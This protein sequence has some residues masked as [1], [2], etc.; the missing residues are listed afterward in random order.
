MK[1]SLREPLLAAFDQPDPDLPC[2]VRFPTNVPT[3]ALL[4]LN[5]DF[6][7]ARA[8]AFA[9]RLAQRT[10]EEPEQLRI[11]IQ[12]ALQREPEPGEIARAAELLES[13]RLE[14][15]VAQA[16]ALRLFALGLLNRNEFLWVD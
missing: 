16:E 3:Q 8:T 11:A 2:A 13:L 4:T 6:M 5:G 7:G 10:E 14:H 15:G 12:L 1:R 9:Q